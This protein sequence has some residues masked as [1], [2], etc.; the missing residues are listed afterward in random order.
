M[1]KYRSK[2]NAVTLIELLIVIAM[3]T[4]CAPVL[5]VVFNQ[6]LREYAK[7]QFL[8]EAAMLAQDIMNQLLFEDFYVL[9]NKNGESD[10]CPIP[11]A[12]WKTYSGVEK[13]YRYTIQAVCVNPNATDLGQGNTPGEGA[14][15]THSNF[16]RLTVRVHRINI[17]P[18]ERALSADVSLTTIVTP[19]RY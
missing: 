16:L 19:W 7:T 4:I 2:K 15:V 17:G 10:F 11:N 13:Q 18:P 6:F 14:V 9:I 5:V 1:Y 8:T 12:D 3:M